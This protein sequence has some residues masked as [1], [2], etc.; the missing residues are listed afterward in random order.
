MDDWPQNRV[1][2]TVVSYVMRAIGLVG[3]CMFLGVEAAL[4]RSLYS[5]LLPYYNS[6]QHYS[7]FALVTTNFTINLICYSPQAFVCID[8][9]V[10][11]LVIFNYL[12]AACSSPG[13]S[14]EY[15]V[16]VLNLKRKT[17]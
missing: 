17:N 14:S 12:M 3:C 10:G 9:L 16:F 2:R 15:Q 8:F 1:G 5:H 4:L 11:A 6:A 13:Y 7:A